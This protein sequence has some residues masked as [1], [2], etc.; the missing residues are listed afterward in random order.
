MIFMKNTQDLKATIV[1]SLLLGNRINQSRK[2]NSRKVSR[3]K[4][5][6]NLQMVHVMQIME[7][8]LQFK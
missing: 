8:R 2:R 3:H 4:K 7:N 6:T 5:R 1:R